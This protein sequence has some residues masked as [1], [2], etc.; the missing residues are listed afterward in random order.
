MKKVIALFLNKKYIFLAFMLLAVLLVGCKEYEDENGYKVI[1]GFSI[2]EST[3]YDEIENKYAQGF[4]I[5]H[6]QGGFSLVE[7]DDDRSY[8]IIPEDNKVPEDY[9]DYIILKRDSDNIYL[10]ATSAMSLFDAIDEISHIGFSSLK[11]EDWYVD[12]A[13]E[14]MDAG[15]IIFAGKYSAPDFELLLK[16]ECSIAIESTMI[17][18][19]PEIMEKIEELGIPVFIDRSSYEED[20]LARL[21]WIKIYGEICDNTEAAEAFFNKQCDI[22]DNLN[23]TNRGK[24]TV[25]FFYMNQNGGVVTKKSS[26]YVPAMIE[27][28]G[29]KYIFDSLLGDTDSKSSTVNMTME[30]FYSAAKDADYIIY[31][32]TIVDSPKSLDELLNRYPLLS[33]FKA[34]A[35]NQVYCMNK[36]VYQ[37]TS[38]T[39]SIIEAINEMLNGL[40]NELLIKL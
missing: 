18:H 39:G 22:I 36:S 26:D 4:S 38:E 37:A 35:E 20:P 23:F 9:E 28:A 21:E 1:K 30:E 11:K 7:V 17:L 5:K 40:D 2:K 6:Y 3:D 24:K 29:G 25:A 13:I 15:D 34:V 19:T 14:K 33:D 31:N 10:A 16:N 12:A 8:L 32:G 27:M